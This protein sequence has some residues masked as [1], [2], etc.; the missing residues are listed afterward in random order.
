M[1]LSSRKSRTPLVGQPI[2]EEAC[3]LWLAPGACVRYRW[4]WG[5]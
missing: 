2:L 3:Y 5:S 1:F 4:R